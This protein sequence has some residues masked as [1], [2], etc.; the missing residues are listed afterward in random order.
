VEKRVQGAG[1]SNCAALAYGG[2]LQ[3]EL[4]YDPTGRFYQVTGGTLGT[5]RFV[6]DGNA[7]VAERWLGKTEQRA[8]WIFCL[9]AVKCAA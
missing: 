4:R 5:Q 1:N 6:Y 8:E 3:A 7:M 9:T 2:A